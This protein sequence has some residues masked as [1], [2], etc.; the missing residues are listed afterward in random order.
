MR[1]KKRKNYLLVIGLIAIFISLIYLVG[2]GERKDSKECRTDS[3]CVP[4]GCCHPTSC[5]SK[6]QAPNCTGIYC[7]QVCSGPLDCGLGHCGCI[8]NKC[9][10]LIDLE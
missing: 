4:A 3:D 8:S 6:E 1:S 5:V 10:V 7:T 2:N 9:E